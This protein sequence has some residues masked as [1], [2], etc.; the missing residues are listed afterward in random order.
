MKNAGSYRI[1]IYQK[2]FYKI[3]KYNLFVM[4]L[5]ENKLHYVLVFEKPLLETEK[6][7][8]VKQNIT[9]LRIN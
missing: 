8:T 9:P 7:K 4:D 6:T 1:S 2:I 5:I 3:S